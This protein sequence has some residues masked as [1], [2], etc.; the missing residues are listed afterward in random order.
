MEERQ[1]FNE[2]LF[3]SVRKK[4][5]LFLSSFM[6]LFFVKEIS[7]ESISF[8]FTILKAVCAYI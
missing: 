4:H 6:S 1:C 8:F 3:V 5:C 7:L 2:G